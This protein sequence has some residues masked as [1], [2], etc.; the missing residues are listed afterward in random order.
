[1]S[2]RMPMAPITL[3]SGSRS[4]EALSV[5]GMTSPLALRGLSRAFRVTPRST[6]S[7]N[8]A[9][10]SRV[11]SALMKRDSDCSSTSSVRNPSSVETASLACR[12]LPSRSETNTGSGAFLI[13]LSA[14]ARALSN[15]R[16]SRRMPMAPIILPPGSRSAEALR[17][18]EM[19]SP[20]ALRGLSR[21]FRVTPRSTTSRRAAR[22]SRVSAGEM[23][24]E[25]DCSISSSGRNPSKAKTASLACRILPSRSE[26]NTGSGAVLIAQRRGVERRRDDLPAGAA[27]VEPRVPRD[28]A[29]HDLA[30]GG[31]EFPGFLRA[32]EAGQRLLQHLVRSKPEQSGDGVVGLQDLALEVG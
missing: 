15:S 3:P 13:K 22:N 29:L 6:T 12:I 27:G 10:N 7:R 5:V 28:P 32:D 24:R 23:I 2:R 31:G 8:A 25:S 20:L 4:A 14:Y 30:Q 21:A 18:A 26:T 1:M 11:S 16:M 17:L 9:V 19:T